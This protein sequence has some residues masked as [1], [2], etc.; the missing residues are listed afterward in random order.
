MA[1]GTFY[2]NTTFKPYFD[3]RK[4]E[5]SIYNKEIIRERRIN[6]RKKQKVLDNIV[7]FF[8]VLFAVISISMLAVLS[9][10]YVKV[11]A[12]D[13]NIEKLEATLLDEKRKNEGEKKPLSKVVKYDE[14]KMKA[15][16]ELNMILPT[17]KNTIY[18]DKSD[19]GFVRQYENIR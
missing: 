11:A 1:S 6:V 7:S 3:M 2:G 17:D 9:Y 18:F 12:I 15:Y 4:F 5:N 14:L 13:R 10:H 19:Q 16:L 8:V